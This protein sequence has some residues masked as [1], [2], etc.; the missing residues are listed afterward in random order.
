MIDTADAVTLKNGIFAVL[1]ALGGWLA[2][3]LGGW[4]PD[5]W[6]LVAFMVIDYITGLVVAFFFHKSPK[7]SCGGV[8]S[9]AGFRGLIKKMM[10]LVFVAVGA[11][12]DGVLNT[13]YIRTAVIL[14]FLANEGLSIVENGALMGIPYPKFLRT[15]LELLRDSVDEAPEEEHPRE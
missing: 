10:L 9:A 6:A 4:T 1:A 5:V 7:T 11:L 14:F 8:S 3:A 15:A 2:K 12:M 13:D